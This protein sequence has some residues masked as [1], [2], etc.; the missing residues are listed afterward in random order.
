MTKC[1][2][3]KNLMVKEKDGVLRVRTKVLLWKSNT[4]YAVCKKCNHEILLK[5]L[6]VSA[7]YISDDKLKK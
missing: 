7:F 5:N 2:N 3:C 1:P 4:C 6:S